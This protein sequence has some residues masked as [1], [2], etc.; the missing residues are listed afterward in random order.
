MNKFFYIFAILLLTAGVNAEELSDKV[1][2]LNSKIQNFT[3]TFSETKSMPKLKKE[4]HKSGNIYFLSPNDLLMDY[5]DPKTD[6]SLLGENL[7]K[8]QRGSHVQ[9]FNLKKEDDRMSVFHKTL[10]YSMRGDVESVAKVNDATIKAENTGVEI[11]FHLKKNKPQKI[12]VTEM[13][14]VYDAP[15]GLIKTLKLIEANGISTTYTTQ[16]MQ[17]NTTIDKAVFSK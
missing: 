1:L 2:A 10:I 11:C 5:T 17:S 3:G 7:F 12:G 8:V 16:N 13:L 4:T 9:K 6:W 15:T 14:L